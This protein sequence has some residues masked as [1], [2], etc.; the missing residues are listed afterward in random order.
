MEFEFRQTQTDERS[1]EA[2]SR[3]LS[4][5]F[6][7]TKKY[8]TDFLRWQYVQNPNGKVV[9]FDAFYQ[10]KLVAH[11]VTIPVVYQKKDAFFKGLLSLNTAT[12]SHFQGKGLFT[13]LADK[14]YDLGRSLGFEFVIGVANQNS[15]HGFVRKLGFELLAPLDVYLYI[16]KGSVKYNKDTFYHSYLTKDAIAWRLKNPSNL[17]LYNNSCAFSETDKSFIKACLSTTKETSYADSCNPFLK[18]EIG[19]NNKPSTLLKFKLPDMLKP[20]P[21]NLIFKKLHSNVEL[22]INNSNLK[23]ELIDFDAY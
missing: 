10:N 4:Q 1:L 21:L 12:D 14:T 2:Y 11:Y 18:M 3:L 5:V 22:D 20:S 7:S 9:G 16:G 23:F 15:T 8:T 13:K 19:I 6:P 17:Y